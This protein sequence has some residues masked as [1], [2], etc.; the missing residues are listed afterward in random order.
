MT[1]LRMGHEGGGHAYTETFRSDSPF[2]SLR[3]SVPT[4]EGPCGPG[5]GLQFGF[6]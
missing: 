4:E 1:S 3:S 6:A 2:S 5:P